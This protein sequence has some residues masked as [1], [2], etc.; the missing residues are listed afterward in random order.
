MSSKLSLGSTVIL[1]CEPQYYETYAAFNYVKTETEFLN[2]DEFKILEYL[3]GRHADAEE[4]A[5]ETKTSY[6]ECA[7]F[8]KRM[9]QL[10]YVRTDRV[11]RE[12]LPPKRTKVSRELFEKFSIPFL[13]APASVDVFITNRCNLKCVHCFS[14]RKER[15]VQ[16]LPLNELMFIFDQMEKMGVL[17]VRINGGEP[18]M[19]PAIDKILL[20]LGTRRFRKVII[21]NGTLLND[22]IAKL[23]KKS[24]VIPTISLD[25]SDADGHDLFRGTNGAFKKTLGGLKILQKNKVQ[26][27]INCCLHAKNLH[28][29][30]SIIKL[31][32]NNG[33][34]RIAFLDLKMVGR[35]K[36]HKEWIPSYIEYEEALASLMMV[37]SKYR[38]IDVSLDVFLSC[39]PLRESIL[40]ARKGYVSCRAGKTEL[41]ICSDGTVYPCNLVIGDPEWNMGNVRAETLFD[42]WFSRNW[43]FFRGAVKTND[44]KECRDC[45][46]L[47]RC[48]NFYCRLLP[49]VTT[50]DAFGPS[51]KCSQHLDAHS[52][53]SSPHAWRRA[54]RTGH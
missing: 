26:Y 35:M 27:G 52:L 13:S 15:N 46:D 50:G 2:E 47:R 11:T 5:R 25:D 16:D 38:E 29:Y 36:D 53:A 43:A 48:R 45:R 30:E 1:R 14:N 4:V 17:E 20:A 40:E 41:S 54:S 12:T 28:K 44:L 19:H 10:G 51:P 34:C 42:V 23:L 3:Y 21:T 32:A 6:G 8:L 33:A 24:N 31:S 39:H 18:L 7:K 9:I 22:E 37:K 49:Y